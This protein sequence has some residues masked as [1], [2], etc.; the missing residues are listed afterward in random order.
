[1]P[2]RKKN[3]NQCK[4]QIAN[5]ER[6]SIMEFGRLVV[7]SGVVRGFVSVENGKKRRDRQG[8]GKEEGRKAQQKK[9]KKT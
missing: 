9:S 4:K 1:M 7:W 2:R 6:S 3:N 5:S 8:Q